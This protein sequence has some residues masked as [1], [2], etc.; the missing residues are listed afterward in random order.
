VVEDQM[1]KTRVLLSAALAGVGEDREED[2]GLVMEAYNII[3]HG[4]PEG[5]V[6]LELGNSPDEQRSYSEVNYG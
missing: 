5:E 3:K 1:Q 4:N 2:W 6:E